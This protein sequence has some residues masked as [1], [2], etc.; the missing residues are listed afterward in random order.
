M[1]TMCGDMDVGRC[2]F[3]KQ[4][5]IEMLEGYKERLEQ[6]AKGVEEAIKDL[7]KNN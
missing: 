4:E 3:T 1:K 5:R 6:E 2:F 7:K